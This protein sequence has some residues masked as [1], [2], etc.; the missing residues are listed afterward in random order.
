MVDVQNSHS[1]SQLKSF[2]KSGVVQRWAVATLMIGLC[3][4]AAATFQ[5][6]KLNAESA[7][8]VLR[9][10]TERGA[11]TV[12]ERMRMYQ[13]GLRGVRGAISVGGG[14]TISHNLFNRYSLTRDLKLEFPGSRGFGFV[15]RVPLAMES[16]FL[17]AARA[18]GAP[19]FEIQTFTPHSGERYVVQFLEPE[20]INRFALGIDIASEDRRRAA[21]EA[22]LLS[23]ETM[24]TA[25]ITL[26]PGGGDVSRSFLLLMPIYE[27]GQTPATVAERQAKGL[28][29]AM[30]PLVPREIM[31]KINFD[32]QF[33]NLRLTDITDPSHP[34]VFY[35]S[36][37][38][39]DRGGATDAAVS[40]DILKEQTERKIYGRTWLI[41]VSTTAAFAANAPE[42]KPLTV[43]LFGLLAT[44]LT[45][46]LATAVGVSRHRRR[47]IVLE[48]ARRATIIENS[49]D[50]IIGQSLD[51]RI[52]SWNRAAERL[53]GY[54]AQLVLGEK[55]SSILLPPDRATEDDEILRRIV[56]G[57]NVETF[58]TVRIDRDGTPIDV[59]IIAGPVREAD[60]RISGAAKHIRDIRLRVREERR[61]KEFSARL[62]REVE[63][64]TQEMKYANKLLQDVLR[65]ASEVAIIASDVYGTITLFNSGAERMLG[66]SADEVIGK[67][68]P[69]LFHL[70]AEVAALAQELSQEF[71]VTIVGYRVFVYRTERNGSEMRRWTYVRKDGSTL[72]ASIVITPLRDENGTLTGYLGIGKDVTERLRAS[73]ALEH[74]K[75]AAESASIAKGRFL[76][77]M[78]HELRTPINGILGMAQMLLQGDV[79]VQTRDKY[80]RII[81]GSGQTL[82]ALLN[83]ILDFSKIEAGKIELEQVSF[84][85]EQLMR[86]VEAL[87]SVAAQQKGLAYAAVWHGP[88]DLQY[89]GDPFRIRQ[90]LTNLVS[91]ALKFTTQ[92]SITIDVT[93]IPQGPRSAMLEFSVT[94]TGM[95]IAEDVREVLFKPFAQGESSTTRKF[96]GT[97]LGLSIVRSLSVIMGG[98]AGVSSEVGKGSRF[99]FRVP[100]HLETR[101][102]RR[103]EAASDRTV[104]VLK[105]PAAP[106]AYARLTG[107]VLVAEDVVTNRLVIEAMLSKFGLAFTMVE[108]GKEAV[109]K[110]T[111]GSHFDIV[112]M[113]V[114][115]P[116]MD[117]YDATRAIRK[118][119][120][121]NNSAS[122]TILALTAAA[123]EDD[124]VEAL[125]AGMDGFL[126]KPLNIDTFYSALAERLPRAEQSAA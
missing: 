61:L 50:A 34:E 114:Q 21:A 9:S 48:Q 121:E 123:Y 81:L 110:M 88:T 43:A 118:W 49:S 85:P 84:S 66:Y 97:G 65:S 33:F 35:A 119:E 93:Q 12:A 99:W 86:E 18:D 102:V 60:G 112:L 53:F 4:T 125:K 95:G 70:P 14:A 31:E 47:E 104:K 75:M 117:G 78:S 96:G 109:A 94:D 90:M 115:M 54:P 107:T 28:G 80:T 7:R 37:G 42:M 64:R 1:S 91:N 30:A 108:N 40:H 2:L 116:E 62:E 45:T 101:A 98:E 6:Q 17:A 92:G 111:D 3:L 51:G 36:D 126:A 20:D 74:A 13:Y 89:V 68:T 73:E 27:N 63:L 41:E 29:W 38:S 122:T 26:L 71:G 25:P 8:A 10:V 72:Q 124:R 113:D 32:R 69:A 19:D 105:S 24:L 44:F 55:V 23:G 106:Q 83:D 15:R 67:H 22:A 77:T 120:K 11:H 100:V 79:D 39:L 87:F 16:Q 5:R 56:A 58:D 103:L 46:A 52:T 57:E 59:T 76:A 82:L